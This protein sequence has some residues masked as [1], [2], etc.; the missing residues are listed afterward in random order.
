MSKWHAQKKKDG[1][2]DFKQMARNLLGMWNK[3][4]FIV[5]FW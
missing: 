5:P 2:L 1:K 4:C 3:V